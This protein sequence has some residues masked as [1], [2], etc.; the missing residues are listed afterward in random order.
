[1]KLL[2]FMRKL[3]EGVDPQPPALSEHA[4]GWVVDEFVRAHCARHNRKNTAREIERVLRVRFV[5][6]WSDRDIREIKRADIVAVLDRIMEA[7][8]PSA[9]NHAYAAARRLFNWCAE[10]GLIEVSPCAKVQRPALEQSRE[11][12]LSDDELAAI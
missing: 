11:R 12:T 5:S 10:R 3:V 4:F 6:A 1:M 2:T 9:A 8:T 7:G